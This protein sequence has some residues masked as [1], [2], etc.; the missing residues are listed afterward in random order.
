MQS[1][2]KTAAKAAPKTYS[3]VYALMSDIGMMRI[4]LSHHIKAGRFSREGEPTTAGRAF[5]ASRNVDAVTALRAKMVAHVGKGFSDASTGDRFAPMPDGA[6]L[7]HAPL[8]PGSFA[9]TPIRA[10]FSLAVS[11][12]S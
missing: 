2:T 6:A 12:L 4:S 11:V 10:W 5:F 3:S 1:K 7:S 9:S 8:N